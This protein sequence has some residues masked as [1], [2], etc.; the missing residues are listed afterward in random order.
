MKTVYNEEYKGFN[1]YVY[2]RFEESTTALPVTGVYYDSVFL[3]LKV[4]EN[5]RIFERFLSKEESIEERRE[6]RTSL[7]NGMK[8]AV[9]KL[10]EE[11]K[12]KID[13]YVRE[14]EMT[15]GLP[16]SLVKNSHFSTL[17]E[18]ELVLN[19]K[20][21]ENL[22]RAT[23]IYEGIAK[24]T[25]EIDELISDMLNSRSKAIREGVVP[26]SIE[27]AIKD[28]IKMRRSEIKKM[29]EAYKQISM[30]SNK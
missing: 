16:E 11:S 1:I 5:K 30:T 25:S 28:L 14:K 23:K 20:E 22:L 27:N 12:L 9:S 3:E 7:H 13:K 24:S 10:V 18:D 15:E 2:A 17:Q 6:N 4:W 21:T 29:N 8:K 19:S 26:T